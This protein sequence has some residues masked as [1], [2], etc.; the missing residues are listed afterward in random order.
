MKLNGKNI[1][2][3]GLGK[4]GIATAKFL[5]ENYKCRLFISDSRKE[6][7]L[8]EEIK[9]LAPYNIELETGSHSKAIYQNKD[10]IV[11][12]PGISI[13]HP[14]LIEAKK[15]NI[16][17][18][19]EI[20]LAYNLSNSKIIAVTGT[21]GKSTTCTLI[22]LLLEEMGIPVTLSG[23]IGTPFISQIDKITKDHVSVLELSSFQLEAMNNFRANIAVFLNIFSDHMDRHSDFNEYLEMKKH[24]FLNQKPRDYAIINE[25]INEKAS[26]LKPIKSRLFTFSNFGKIKKGTFIKDDIIIFNDGRKNHNLVNKKIIKLPGPHNLENILAALTVTSLFNV[27]PEKIEKVLGSFTGISHRLQII[28]EINQIRFYN[29]SKSTNP[30]STIAALR[31]FEG[32]P[33]ILI[34]GGRDK[35]NDFEP[36]ALEIIDKCKSLTLIGEASIIIER[37][38][39]KINNKWSKNIFKAKT[40]KEAVYLSY[41]NA[42]KGDVI[43]LSPA[44]ASFDMFKSAEDRGKQFEEIVKNF[45]LGGEK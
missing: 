34:A 9:A 36:L 39:K 24:V 22:Y 19:S 25:N 45:E 16:P 4:T 17:V 26:I 15:D 13:N 11:I 12:S 27:S 44:C 29:D 6:S 28:K 30:D 31:S 32:S 14:I 10:L 33:I 38:I 7:E 2:V 1:T 37:E 43:I 21:K 3:M 8:S 42:S 23:N 40:L 35:N 20:E 41:Q 5:S 18:I